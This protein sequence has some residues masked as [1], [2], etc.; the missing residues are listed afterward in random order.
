M[1]EA[2]LSTT[3]QFSHPNEPTINLHTNT[4][5]ITYPEY[6]IASFSHFQN[7]PWI[8][9]N[10][11]TYDR[12]FNHHLL[13]KCDQRVFF[14]IHVIH[15]VNAIDSSSGCIILNA[16]CISH[17]TINERVCLQ[18]KHHCKRL[19]FFIQQMLFTS[20]ASNKT[21]PL[22]FSCFSPFFHPL[23]FFHFL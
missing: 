6:H 14:S 19:Y 3:I 4:I 8:A 15:I 10:P 7:M 23:F 12:M 5:W 18:E 2:P 1:D 16:A 21:G 13:Q 11:F 22:S 9:F 20:Q 17:I